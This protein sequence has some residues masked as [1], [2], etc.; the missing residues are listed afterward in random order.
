MSRRGSSVVRL[1]VLLSLFLLFPALAHAATVRGRVLDTR[2][3]EPLVAVSVSLQGVPRGALTDA[4]GRFEILDVPPGAYNVQAAQLG[5]KRSVQY[6]LDVMPARPTELE[7]LLEAE[8]VSTDSV[9][10]TAS[11]FARRAA[12]PLSVRTIGAAEIERFPGG[13]RDL[14]KALQSTPGVASTPNF[15]NDLIVRGGAPNENRFYLDGIEVPNINHF[16][17]QG[18]SGGPVGMIDVR[19]IREVDVYTSAFPV[20]RGNALSSVMDLLLRD[21]NA[22]HRVLSATVGASDLGITADGPCGERGSYILSARRSYLQFLF[23]ALGLPFLPTYN[24]AQFK[25][26]AR[27]GDRDE[28]TLLGLGAIDDFTLNRGAD[29][30]EFKRYLLEQLPV[31]SQWNY[32]LGGVWKRQSSK[33]VTTA[34]LSRNQ[35]DNQAHKFQGNDDTDPAK[36]LLDYDSRETENKLR[37]ERNERRGGFQLEYGGGAETA[38]YTTATFQRTATQTGPIVIDYDSRLTLAKAALFAQASRTLAGDRLT[39]SAGVRLDASDYSSRTRRLAQQLSPRFAASYALSPRWRLNMSAGRYLQLPAYTVLGFRDSTGA[40]ANR[41]RGASYVRA[42]H[43]VGG[44]E[45]A[46]T[47]NS[48]ITAEAFLKRYADYPF[49]LRDR[50]SLANLGADFGVIGNAPS[51]PTSRGRAY[52][53]ELLAQQRLYRGYYGILAYTF[54]RSEFTTRDDS[55]EPSAWDNRHVLSLTGGKKWARGYELGVRWKYL[56]GAPYTPDNVAL[57]AQQGVWDVTGRG[58]PDYGRLNSER[59]GPLHQLDV[60]FDRKWFRKHSSIDLYFDIQNLY[61]FQPRLAPILLVDRDAGGAPVL[62]PGNPGSYRMHFTRGDTG[63][64]LPTIGVMFE[65]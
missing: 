1:V 51:T 23:K 57:S 65:F 7:F 60:R 3:R 22:E 35:L 39:L 28:F 56:G 17:T 12:S 54:V 25:L 49:L 29:D 30:T 50:I 5:Y 2:T 55:F 48:R 41:E 52:G 36:R 47:T 59:N 63:T 34:V 64:L 19:F 16:A 43:L 37:V 33:G 9:S 21:G 44:I 13:G 42:D 32:T 61:A 62:D 4:Q 53:L 15:R 11:P 45:L 8:I 46:T 31:N 14:S 26:R 10:V 6:E 40:L 20:A 38:E 58:V 24:D 18:S 27:L